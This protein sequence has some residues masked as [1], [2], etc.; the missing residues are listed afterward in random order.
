[1]VEKRNEWLVVRV[2]LLELAEHL[3]GRLADGVRGCGR[4]AL[5]RSRPRLGGGDEH[6]AA[7]EGSINAHAVSWSGLKRSRPIS[8]HSGIYITVTFVSFLLLFFAVSEAHSQTA[9]PRYTTEDLTTLDTPRRGAAP[10]TLVRG[11]ASPPPSG[12]E[13]APAP[14]TPPATWSGLR[15]DT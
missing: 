2:E 1:M 5:A 3:S 6:R 14:D 13:R 15:G 4:R 9:E 10:E 8:V 12:G 11:T 7:R